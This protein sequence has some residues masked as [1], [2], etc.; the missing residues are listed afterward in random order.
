M[1][2]ILRFGND[3]PRTRVPDRLV[4]D[5]QVLI[6][7]QVIVLVREAELDGEPLD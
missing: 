7:L 4:E 5:R 2:H 1:H 3:L 6:Y